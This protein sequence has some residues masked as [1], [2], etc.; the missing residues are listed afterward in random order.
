MKIITTLALAASIVNIS[1]SIAQS[2]P[3]QSGYVDLPQMRTA[4]QEVEGYTV[5]GKLGTATNISGRIWVTSYHTVSNTKGCKL[6]TA[7]GTSLT[8]F[9]IA[10]DNQA[11]LALIKSKDT[12]ESAALST[13]LSGALRGVGDSR[14]EAIATRP[15]LNENGTFTSVVV[16]AKDTQ[17]LEGK[18]GSPIVNSHNE[19]VGIVDYKNAASE[20]AGNGIVPVGYIR[21]LLKKKA[22]EIST[23]NIS[24]A[25]PQTMAIKCY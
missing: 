17:L 10:V 19:I 12:G 1:I 2:A 8:A 24:T 18:S 16:Q 14:F 15:V 25:F 20:I 5:Y 3:I 11:D 9:I 23:E 22:I 7:E 13:D 4:R 6:V 21:E